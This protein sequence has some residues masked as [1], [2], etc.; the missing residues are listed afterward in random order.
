MF[1]QFSH[2]SE[3]VSGREARKSHVSR[4]ERLSAL[5]VA[6]APPLSLL[7]LRWELMPNCSLCLRNIPPT[8]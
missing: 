8:P 6:A 3:A 4:G 1:N 5:L 7:T 2:F